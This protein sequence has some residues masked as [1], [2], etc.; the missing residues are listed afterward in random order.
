MDYRLLCILFLY[1]QTSD[2]LYGDFGSFYS[3]A[4]VDIYVNLDTCMLF[5]YSQASGDLYVHLD[6]LCFVPLYV[7]VGPYTASTECHTG[8]C[9]HC[10]NALNQPTTV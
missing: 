4:S 10:D 2:D 1:S 8:Y 3:P 9:Y 6:I 7:S 5:L